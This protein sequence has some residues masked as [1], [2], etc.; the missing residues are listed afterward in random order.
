MK[1]LFK[2]R[3]DL[4]IYLAIVILFTFFSIAEAY[5]P[6]IIIDQIKNKSIVKNLVKI[7]IY[8]IFIIIICNF[9]LYLKNQKEL[10][11]RR[12][13]MIDLKNNIAKAIFSKDIVEFNNIGKDYF[14][15]LLTKDIEIYDSAI[16]VSYF[17]IIESIIAFLITSIFLIGI[18]P[19]FF[20]ISLISVVLSMIIPKILNKKKD[21][22][23]KNYS[24]ENEKLI[25][26]IKDSIFGSNVIYDFG[27][28]N[29]IEEKFK[30]KNKKVLSKDE[31][32][33]RLNYII[34]SET[35]FTGFLFI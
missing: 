20:P 4:T 16:N 14:H 10:K 1:K 26:F 21:A 13:F 5:L 18:K 27:I 17:R 23:K 24:K 35:F 11:I 33:S 19:V 31:N 7:I 32:L 25:S 30:E 29:I 22:C 6:G 9:F 2:D 15:N 28:F 12:N 3:M 8:S 34:E